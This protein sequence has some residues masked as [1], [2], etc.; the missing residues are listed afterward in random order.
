MRAPAE[1]DRASAPVVRT[2][3]VAARLVPMLVVPILVVPMLV[4]RAQT[5]PAATPRIGGARTT[6]PSTAPTAQPVVPGLSVA[7]AT[8]S[9]STGF[10]PDPAVIDGRARGARDAASLAP[11]CPGFVG[12]SASHLLALD[13]RFG[14][15]R[16]FAT[17]PGNLVIAVRT[18]DDRWLCN[19]DRFGPHPSVEGLFPPGRVEIWVGTQARGGESPYSLRVTEMR[20]VRPGVGNESEEDA[21][22][23][24]ARD[25]GLEVEAPTGLHQAIRLRRGFLPD[26]RMLEGV[27]G[28]TIDIGGLGGA[29]SGHVTA[30]PTHIVTLQTDFDFLQL[31]AET[32]E[33][34]E[35]TIAVLTPEGRFICGLGDHARAQASAPRWAPGEYR[36]WVGNAVEGATLRHRLGISEIR[37]VR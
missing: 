29:C 37:R 22:E 23:A 36:V 25:L 12:D 3:I 31:Y 5:V 18:A 7:G 19:D 14:F 2:S 27:S 8:V 1:T 6:S 20:S 24:L 15:L 10:V 21:G 30:Q 32:E 11:Q 28:G 9:L 17:G 16:I 13:T 4:A 33:G 35:P 34:T 26:P